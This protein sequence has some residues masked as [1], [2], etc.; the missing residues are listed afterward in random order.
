MFL[1]Q[2]LEMKALGINVVCLLYSCMK[3]AKITLVTNSELQPEIA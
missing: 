1:F 3:N 2:V